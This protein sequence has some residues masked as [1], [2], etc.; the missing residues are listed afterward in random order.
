MDIV[1]RYFKEY[2]LV[3][4]DILGNKEKWEKVLALVPENILLGLTK[5][6]LRLYKNRQTEV[7]YDY[8]AR[9]AINSQNNV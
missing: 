1:A 5:M 2:A 9:I 8:L 4:Q 6:E 3:G 7:L